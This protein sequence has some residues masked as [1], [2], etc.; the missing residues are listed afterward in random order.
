MDIWR[1]KHAEGIE[2]WSNGYSEEL[3]GFDAYPQRNDNEGQ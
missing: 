3:K 1:H 2:D